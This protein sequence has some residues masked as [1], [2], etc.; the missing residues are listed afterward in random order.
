MRFR[1]Q[2]PWQC[3]PEVALHALV[4]RREIERADVQVATIRGAPQFVYK[5]ALESHAAGEQDTDM[6][7]FDSS[8]GVRE[9][10]RRRRV[11]PLDVVDGDKKLTGARKS[12]ESVEQRNTSSM[13][14]GRRAV[15]LLEDERARE[16]RALTGRKRRQR[17]VENRVEKIA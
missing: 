2:W 7:A 1:Q 14:I 13:R 4:Q 8:H 11:E 5:R 6:L 16:R 10:P 12:S 9:R 3:D 15:D 17:L